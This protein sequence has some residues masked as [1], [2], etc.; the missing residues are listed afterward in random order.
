MYEIF[1]A[2]TSHSRHG[3]FGEVLLQL[4]DRQV[5]IRTAAPLEQVQVALGDILGG[6]TTTLRREYNH[7]APVLDGIGEPRDLIG[8]MLDEVMPFAN[9]TSGA[10]NEPHEMTR[11]QWGA[12]SSISGIAYGVM[13]C[14]THATRCVGGDLPQFMADEFR[15]RFGYGPK[16]P[17]YDGTGQCNDRH[18]VHV[19]YALARGRAVPDQVLQEYLA[20][21]ELVATDI[22]WFERVLREPFLR[23]RF[24]SV[25]ELVALGLI[26][27]QRPLTEEN[28]P[29]LITALSALPRDPSYVDVDNQLYAHGFV[30]LC[31]ESPLPAPDTLGQPVNEFAKRLHAE[32][33]KFK[34]K[35]SE[36]SLAEQVRKGKLTQ[37]DMDQRQRAIDSIGPRESYSWANKVAQAIVAKDLPFMLH[38]L[39]DN[40][41]EASQRAVEREFG[42][43]LRS[44]RAAER[45][46]AV[47]GLAGHS[48]D[49]DYQRAER[50]LEVENARRKAQAELAKDIERLPGAKSF[51]AMHR[52]RFEGEVITCD[53]FVEK[54]IAR[55]YTEVV[56]RPRGA[57]RTY[58]LRKP[59]EGC[60]YGVKLADGT[61]VY[62]RL[63]TVQAAATAPAETAAA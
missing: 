48:S 23:G 19:A 61:L 16:G 34:T 4:N 45:R 41:N 15:R 50:N 44:V 18:E 14:F 58:Y 49:E 5:G 22:H 60:M 35:R 42:V 25:D 29:A 11:T 3:T 38:V 36:K 8:R 47:F 33:V 17:T 59:E 13:P 26:G 56:E 7:I 43:K 32:L 51:A 54:L 52:V 27:K 20:N 28:L 1:I 37:R 6:T 40:G 53:V 31:P 10:I 55:G 9:T 24:R 2:G 57:A 30:S 63:L 21:D 62:A 39:C 46:R 12:I